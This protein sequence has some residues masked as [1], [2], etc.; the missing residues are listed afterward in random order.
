[1]PGPSVV[2]VDTSPAEKHS[3]RISRE[4]RKY[5]ELFRESIRQ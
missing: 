2:V 5:H 3:L 4:P 1:M